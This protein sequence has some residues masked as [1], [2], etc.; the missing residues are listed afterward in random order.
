V[1]GGDWVLNDI[2]IVSLGKCGYRYS[3][4]ETILCDFFTSNAFHAMPF[5]LSQF[6]LGSAPCLISSATMSVLPLMTARW[7]GV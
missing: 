6:Q 7:S 3:S 1:L 5:F 4:Y 2:S